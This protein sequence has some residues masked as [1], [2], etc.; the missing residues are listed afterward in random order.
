MFHSSLKEG[1]YRKGK[2]TNAYRKIELDELQL[3]LDILNLKEDIELVPLIKCIQEISFRVCSSLDLRDRYQPSP[4]EY[5][6]NND[7]SVRFDDE[8]VPRALSMLKRNNPEMYSLFEDSVYSLFPEF[9]SISLN[10]YTIADQKQ[11]DKVVTLR[12][13]GQKDESEGVEKEI[14]FKIREH[15]YRLFIKSEYLNQPLSIAN[16]STG[17]K[18]IIWLLAN[19]YISNLASAGIV[20]VEEIETSIHPRMM[21]QLLEALSEALGNSSLLVSSHSP[22]LIQYLKPEKIYIGLPNKDGV[23]EFRR[24]SKSKVKLLLSRAREMEVSVGEYIFEMLSGDSDDYQIL[25][26]YLEVSEK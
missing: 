11:P 25:E 20:G 18:R 12:V 17:T 5:I 14:P 10:E 21:R 7:D 8:D 15:I 22:Y 16:M 2:S 19:A 3:A 24:I 26:S 23:A 6:E 1:K 13:A 4:L 9:T